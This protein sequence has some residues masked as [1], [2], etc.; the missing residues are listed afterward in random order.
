MNA[1]IYRITYPM[2]SQRRK[3][4]PYAVSKAVYY[5]MLIGSATLNIVL[6]SFLE[7]MELYGLDK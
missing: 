4:L 7:T 2:D 5:W 1:D 3:D 6:S